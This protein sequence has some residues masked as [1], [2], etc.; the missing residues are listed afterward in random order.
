MLGIYEIFIF[1]NMLNDYEQFFGCL[2]TI[3]E[4]TKKPKELILVNS[5]KKDIEKKF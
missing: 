4:Q 5:G 2:Q 1:W 3:I